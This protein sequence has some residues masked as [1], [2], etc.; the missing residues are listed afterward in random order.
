MSTPSVPAR[1]PKPNYV[2]PE[3]RQTGAT[4]Y[5]TILIVAVV[6]I[7]SLRYY[8]RIGILKQK[9]GWDDLFIGLSLVCSCLVLALLVHAVSWMERCIVF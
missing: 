2:N 3:T 6:S 7:V 5:N 1:W 4:A 9:L 8:S